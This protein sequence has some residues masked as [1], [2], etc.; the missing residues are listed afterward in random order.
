MESK[1]HRESSTEP[2]GDSKEY[3]AEALKRNYGRNGMFN[4]FKAVWI[5]SVILLLLIG[6]WMIYNHESSS[7]YVG[8]RMSRAGKPGTIDGYGVLSLAVFM[9]LI[10]IAMV[11]PFKRKK[12]HAGK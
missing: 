3:I 5:G 8:G 11:W 10:G 6:C 9:A 12:P 4:S 2:G 7:G 1:S